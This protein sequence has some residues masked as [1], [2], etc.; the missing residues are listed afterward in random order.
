MS[1]KNGVS[2]CPRKPRVVAF[3]VTRRCQMNCVHCRASADA[4][5][6]DELDTPKCKKIIK[7]IADYNRCVLIFTGG[8]PFERAD[9]FDL[10]DYAGFCG[11]MISLATCGYNFDQSKAERL[12]KTGVLT[13]SFSLDSDD[14]SQHDNFRQTPGAFEKTLK[15]IDIAKTAGLKFQINTTVT[16]L[17]CSKLDKIEA[18]A[19]NLGAYCFNP[20]MLVPAGRA[21]Q[22][23]DIALTAG[24]YEKTLKTVADLKE[25][26]KI[27]VR[28]T[29]APRFAVVFRQL[30]PEP[31]KK[32]FLPTVA[33]AKVGGCLAAGDFA[34]I[35][36]AGDV[37]T[38]GFLNI[39]AGNILESGSFGQIWKNSDFL[40][41]IRQKK[42]A[43]KCGACNFIE[44]CGG[45]RARA[46]AR[47]ND[48]LASDPLCNYNLSTRLAPPSLWRGLRAATVMERS[49]SVSTLIAAH[50]EDDK[51]SEVAHAINSLPDVSHNYLRKHYYNLWFTLK[52]PSCHFDRSPDLSGRSGEIS[53]IEEIIND[54]SKRFNTPFYS[55]PTTRH[56]KLDSSAIKRHSPPDNFNA[57][58]CCNAK[59][60]ILESAAKFLCDLPQVSHCYERKTLPDWPYNLYVMMHEKDTMRIEKIV[61]AFTKK[62]AIEQFQVLPTIKSLKN[63]G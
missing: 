2:P 52:T 39:S 21:K 60:D 37:Q 51:L 24:E 30:Y 11:L 19:E 49:S 10:I 34:F 23:S 45:C 40:N 42:F 59:G 25:K 4:D 54:L 15:A 29:C 38:C 61:D 63:K 18:M 5:F 36:Y 47:N 62:F 6:K 17:N 14:A 27:D 55:F 13:L 20:F 46:F 56:R 50:I 28:F 57:L 3:E 43:G 8:E 9:I 31:Q 26:S 32:A 22:L 1:E 44:S 33:S 48:Y 35:S 58:F 7:S 12:K 16:K 41:S 53:P